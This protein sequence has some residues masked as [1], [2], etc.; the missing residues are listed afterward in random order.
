MIFGLLVCVMITIA[1]MAHGYERIAK[2]IP[3]L[4]LCAALPALLYWCNAGWYSCLGVLIAWGWRI[5]LRGG[6][7]AEAELDAMD[8]IT[9][10]NASH[11]DKQRIHMVWKAYYYHPL[12][13]VLGWIIV[14]RFTYRHQPYTQ[15]T[16]W[17]A[18]RKVEVIS[19]AIVQ[20]PYVAF[21]LYLIVMLC[22]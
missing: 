22:A 11:T 21:F 18:R 2:I 3:T 16:F 8:T 17:D 13:W 10:R 4:A 15:G 14:W 5:F 12:A 7:Q 9:P 1:S 20:A 6:R 19:G